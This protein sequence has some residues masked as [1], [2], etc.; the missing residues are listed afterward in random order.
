VWGQEPPLFDSIS[1]ADAIVNAKV[2]LHAGNMLMV[3][4]FPATGAR[5]VLGCGKLPRFRSRFVSRS[6]CLSRPQ[7]RPL[8]ALLLKLALF[9]ARSRALP[10]CLSRSLSQSH[11][12]FLS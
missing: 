1:A 12:V 2:Q 3:R 5:S 9:Q 10:L 7:A 11:R 4:H 6:L 8:A